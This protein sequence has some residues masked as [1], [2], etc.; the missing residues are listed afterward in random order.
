MPRKI[1]KQDPIL[2][3]DFFNSGFISYR[4]QLFSP[5]RSIGINVVA[6]HDSAVAGQDAENTD[7]LEWSRRPGYSRFCSEPLRAK[8][9]V[10]QFYSSRSLTSG[11]V[12]AFIDTNQRLAIFS[13]TAI[14]TIATKNT[15]AQ[16]FPTTVGGMTYFSDGAAADLQKWDGSLLSPWGLAA[17]TVAPTVQNVIGASNSGT[18]FWQPDTLFAFTS[19]ILDPNGNIE[20][21]SNSYP[22]G[23]ETRTN[24][25]SSGTESSS[26]SGFG[27][28]GT[29]SQSTYT[30]YNWQTTVHTYTSLTLYCNFSANWTVN[31]SGL[32]VEGSATYALEYSLDGGSSFVSFFTGGGSSS[33]YTPTTIPSI[34]IPANQD[35]TKVQGRVNT[36]VSGDG[37]PGSSW[38]VSMSVYSASFYT[39]GGW[40][41]GSPTITGANE[42]VWP[43]IIATTIQ[44]GGALWT[45]YGPVLTWFPATNFLPPVVVLDTNGNLQLATTTTST[46]PPWDGSTH[47][48]TG[49][50]V[51]F[52]GN[53]WTATQ[54][55]NGIAPTANYMTATTTG[56]VTTTLSYWVLSVNP[57]ATGSVAPTWNT[58]VGGTT[59][60]GDFTWTNLGQGSILAAFGYSYVYGFR[61]TY[62]H[63]TT[64]SPISFNTGPSLGPQQVAITSFAINTNVVTFQGV[65][66]FMAGNT[67]SVSN[68]STGTYLN[69][70]PLVVLSAGLSTTQFEAA[71]VHGNVLSTADNGIAIPLIARL[72]QT[73]TASLLCNSTA[74]ITAV[75]V[76]AN[77]VTITAANN[78]SPGL[79]VTLSGLTTAIFLNGQ[80]VQVVNAT[81]TQFQVYFVTPD[82]AT[83]SDTGTAVFNAV[84]IYRVSDGGGLYLFCG[85]VTNPGANTSWSYY[86]FVPDVDLD[87]LLVAQQ[88]HLNDPP[89]GAPGSLISSVGTYTVYWQG[90][91]WM[92]V[93]N[94]VYFTTGPDCTN[95]IP[96]ES[97]PPAYRFQFAGPVIALAPLADGLTVWLSDRVD[98]I[99]GGPETVSFYPTDLWKNFGISSPNCL[100]QDGDRILVLTTQ[101]QH[102]SISQSGRDEIGHNVADYLMAN[103]PSTSSYVTMHRSG[104]DIG[105]FLAN[106]S[107]TILR[108]GERIA[109]W[110]VPAKPVGGCGALNSIETS[111]GVQTLMMAPATPEGY[112]LGRD[113]TTWQDNGENYTTCDV[114]IGSITLSQPG[115][116]LVAL[117]HI[118]G[119]FD[120]VGSTPTIGILPNEINAST[121]ATGGF[122]NLPEVIPEPPV[123][124]TQASTSLMSLRFPVNAM[125]SQLASQWMRHIQVR[126]GFEPENYPNTLKSLAFMESQET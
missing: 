66:N 25:A 2:S 98:V 32:G 44:D 45:N 19:V 16:G 68:L 102:Y 23:S 104:E 91:L 54:N 31:T 116:P 8:E 113:L 60:D 85:A 53:Y 58:A 9:T 24:S 62:G 50:T 35:L 105:S 95:G 39:I 55:S 109:T 6:F 11:I 92:A 120:A 121:S 107:D 5:F 42:P 29:S 67:F 100:F 12:N 80:Q 99:L 47:W 7:F 10:N 48:T 59:A 112:L 34:T 14:T 89:P 64:S 13:P 125:D 22:T 71:F 78:F 97:W 96:E 63:L 52:G 41:S 17:P 114:V 122:I 65:N 72:S 115:A 124:Q 94:Y 75:A 30:V 38:S 26:T 87:E 57:I 108:Y 119:Y 3:L 51:L 4:S 37:G 76:S 84:E 111:V 28:G 106:G 20:L 27:P 69:N 33:G 73:G 90:R 36:S 15:S 40:G 117:Q 21:Q 70:V 88:N 123:G 1:A 83:A 82:S 110:S 118:I 18:G 77:L 103:F 86:D 56:G 79:W 101:G 81:S 61:T 93:G 43:T 126:I 46:V 49:R 74:T